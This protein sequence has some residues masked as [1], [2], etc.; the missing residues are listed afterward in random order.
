M[1]GGVTMR[2]KALSLILLSGIV[3]GQQARAAEPQQLAETPPGAEVITQKKIDSTIP[4]VA[5]AS[6]ATDT[7]VNKED[8]PAHQSD[9]VGLQALLEDE[10]KRTA[11]TAYTVNVS[12]YGAVGA[13]YT[14][15]HTWAADNITNNAPPSYDDQFS[16]IT[17]Y[18]GLNFSGNLREDPKEEFDLK[19]SLMTYFTG[20]TVY[21][22]DAN[23]EWDLLTT[24]NTF[25]RFFT[26]NT[27]V[28]QQQ[29]LFGADNQATE[30]Q[31]PTILVAQ[32]LYRY[33][34]E[35]LALGRDIGLKFNTGF[36]NSVDN[37]TG[38]NV[39]KIALSLAAYNGQG[40][41][42]LD[43]AG[44]QKKDLSAKVIFTPWGDQYFSDLG[45]LS[46]GASAWWR[47]FD[48]RNSD[49]G[50]SVNLYGAQIQW[51]K[52][53]FLLTGEWVDA[54][55][56]RHTAATGP[57]VNSQS[58]VGTFFYTPTA[59]PDWQ[60]LVRFDYFNPNTANN[61]PA[62][63]ADKT[64]TVTAGFNWFFYQTEPLSRRP[65]PIAETNRV[66]KFQ[67]NYI[68]RF[69]SN[70]SGQTFNQLGKNQLLAELFFNF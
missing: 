49:P 18:A 28:G 55:N 37:F 2:I 43:A 29:Y 8:A 9:I 35:G 25:E 57:Q 27:V 51:L 50:D 19:Y 48:I 17:P 13:A 40:A 41:N 14:Q 62:I 7:G 33:G 26:L 38:V 6:V 24:K 20:T 30:D 47:G 11:T 65:Y 64:T 21:L 32:Y 36:F 59:L 58:W 15:P 66:I 16:F 69:E 42:T 31:R 4:P 45:Q 39:A 61:T 54:N 34:M 23:L 52:K 53:P 46:F 63:E 70:T 10:L 67:L 60:P 5:P 56:V 22:L 12:G 44:S 68:W 1:K 3:L